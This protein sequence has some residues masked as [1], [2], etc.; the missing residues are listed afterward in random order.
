MSDR[1][2]GFSQIIYCLFL[3]TLGACVRST[4]PDVK[5]WQPDVV[6]PT[7]EPQSVDEIQPIIQHETST[8][9]SPDPQ[10]SPTPDSP[11][12]IPGLR[13]VEEQHIVQF[14]E[15]LGII[16]QHYNVPLGLIAQANQITN[17]NILSVGQQLVIPA[18]NPTSIGTGFKIISDSELIAGPNTANFDIAG[19]IQEKN[20]YLHHHE[21]E[22]DGKLLK[23][24][25]IVKFIA[26]DYS[27]NPKI[28]LALLEYQS[29]WVTDPNPRTKTLQYPMGWHETW[30][31]GLY[32]QLAWAADTLNRGYYGW[33]EN[34][35]A[36]WTLTDYS[37]V[38][39]NPTI[40]SGTAAVQYFFS[41]LYGYKTWERIVSQD[42]FTNIYNE[43]FGYPFSNPYEPVIPDDLV[44]P[45][46]QL[47]FERDVVWAYTSGPHGGWGDG[48]TWAALDFAPFGDSRGC[49]M[50]DYWIVA[51]ADGLIVRS[52]D[53][54]VV[55]DLDSDGKEQT[56]W[57]VLYM[58]VETRDRVN[59]G[60][61]LKAGERIGH[62]SCEGGFSNGTHVHL[63][64]RYNGE[65]ISAD[66]EIPFVLDGWTSAS[67]GNIYDGYLTK[68]STRLE[69]YNGSS[70]INAIQR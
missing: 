10:F 12:N 51:V 26:R 66:G 5:P 62:P 36:S 60:R 37:V 8:P 39:V 47:P 30:R 9:S 64:R 28:L 50:S 22:V 45:A 21:E 34:D 44:Q 1:K 53:G 13:I 58:H 40:N 20:G 31:E 17:I 70:A 38:P 16:A 46:M 23:G 3:I 67:A 32:L 42:G 4:S 57:T 15:T 27:V 65:W 52:K 48:S 56:G 63:S 14:G 55:Q 6:I 25:Q 24:N 19:F 18:P 33:R 54:A 7:Q 68:G 59:E 61:Y 35:F 29:K 41:V 2:V 43:L 49:F 11:H 69:A